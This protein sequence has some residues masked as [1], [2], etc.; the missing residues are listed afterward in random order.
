MYWKLAI[1][2]VWSGSIIV[3]LAG[4]PSLVLGWDTMLI[5]G[6]VV[7]I[8]GLIINLVKFLDAFFDQTVSRLAAGKPPVPIGGNG[9]TEMTVEKTITTVSTDTPKKDTTSK[10]V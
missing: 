1:W 9:H 3:L 2:K 7:A 6:R 8:I 5:S 10:G 4:A